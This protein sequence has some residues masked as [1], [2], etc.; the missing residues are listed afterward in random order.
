MGDAAEDYFQLKQE[1][2]AID[3]TFAPLFTSKDEIPFVNLG[4][5]I[6]FKPIFGRNL[7]FNYVF[8]EPR[9][10]APMH[11]HPEEQ[12]GTVLEGEYEFEMN[13]EKRMIRPG[14]V[15]VVPPNVP[16]AARTFEQGCFA[17]DIFSPPRSGFR[18]MLDRVTKDQAAGN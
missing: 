11:A 7:L 14:D 1:G 15:Y 13:G 10:E 3:P 5:G 18:E 17:V 4:K 9:T 2:A 16:H 6:K 8:F 12:M